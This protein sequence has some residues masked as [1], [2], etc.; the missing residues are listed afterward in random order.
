[1]PIFN[2]GSTFKNKKHIGRIKFVCGLSLVGDHLFENSHLERSVSDGNS[3]AVQWL[4]L[5]TS[6]AR[7]TGPIPGWGIKILHVMWQKKKKKKREKE[8]KISLSELVFS[9]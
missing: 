6:T 9:P 5:H 3:L 7:D 8:T 4:R 2:T 1:M